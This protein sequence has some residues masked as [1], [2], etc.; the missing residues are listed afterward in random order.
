MR[1]DGVFAMVRR[2]TE[3]FWRYCRFRGSQP[4]LALCLRL[5]FLPL[6]REEA[7]ALFIACG[8]LLWETGP[9]MDVWLLARLPPMRKERVG[10]NDASLPRRARICCRCADSTLFAPAGQKR[11]RV[12]APDFGWF[13]GQR[14]I[15]E[16][17]ALQE[18]SGRRA[19]KT[20]HALLR[21]M[22]PPRPRN[23]PAGRTAGSART[24]SRDQSL[25]NPFLGNGGRFPAAPAPP[26]PQAAGPCSWACR[27][28]LVSPPQPDR[29]AERPPPARGAGA[30]RSRAEG[31]VSRHCRRRRIPPA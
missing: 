15:K 18:R 29:N 12:D 26:T 11:F 4:C 1:T 23:H 8:G 13:A 5:F 17:F 9:G 24:R 30:R 25:E 10:G 22:R 7:S 3:G 21:S 19:G 16:R 28:L 2:K 14:R 6:R 31:A 20:K 27:R